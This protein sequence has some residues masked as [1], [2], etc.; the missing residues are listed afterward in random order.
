MTI[1][2]TAVPGDGRRVRGFHANAAL[3]VDPYL[4]NTTPVDPVGGSVVLY[5]TKVKVVKA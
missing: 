2:N 1:D 3:P 5:D 4:K